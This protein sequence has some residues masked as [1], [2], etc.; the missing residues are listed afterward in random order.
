MRCDGRGPTARPPASAAGSTCNHHVDGHAWHSQLRCAVAVLALWQRAAPSLPPSLCT[1]M[2]ACAERAL[3][4]AANTASTLCVGFKLA[5]LSV[6]RPGAL[7]RVACQAAP[8][9]GTHLVV[10]MMR[11][12]TLS[13]ST[14]S[15]RPAWLPAAASSALPAGGDVGSAAGSAPA[16]VAEVLESGRLKAGRMD[17][18]CGHAQGPSWKGFGPAPGRIPL[19]CPSE[20]AGCS[21]VHVTRGAKGRDALQRLHVEALGVQGFEPAAC[22]PAEDGVYMCVRTD[23]PAR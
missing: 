3:A 20:G 19:R 12:P 21:S 22:R 7:V 8:G 15:S 9:T 14:S 23:I 18:G 11:P 6:C 4:G 10:C 13:S 17:G 5:E 2:R 16:A 1:W